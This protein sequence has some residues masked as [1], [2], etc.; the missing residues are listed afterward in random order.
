MYLIKVNFR[1]NIKGVYAY[2]EETAINEEHKNIKYERILKQW[3]NILCPYIEVN[4]INFEERKNFL[5]KLIQ[6]EINYLNSKNKD[7][8][9]IIEF[10]IEVID[11]LNCQK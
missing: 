4:K 8:E 9:Q 2:N 10:K 3:I 7:G 6:E 11:D 1:S 5:C